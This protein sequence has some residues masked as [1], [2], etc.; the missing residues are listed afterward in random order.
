M[1]ALSETIWEASHSF[2]E[3]PRYFCSFGGALSTLETLSET[4][5][6]LHAAG[7]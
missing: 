1:T 2:I 4:I 7:G 3:R 6:A 5:P